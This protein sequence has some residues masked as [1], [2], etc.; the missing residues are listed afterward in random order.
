MAYNIEIE[1]DEIYFVD[2][3]K[4]IK[5]NG[6][7]YQNGLYFI[8]L[9]PTDNIS[10]KYNNF[11]YKFT[12]EEIDKVIFFSCY[13]PYYGQK[14][15]IDKEIQSRLFLNELDAKNFLNSQHHTQ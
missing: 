15:W 12:N 1:F 5:S 7:K 4:I 10:I 13:I 9:S 3:E 8:N 11:Q 6:G 2:S 14:L